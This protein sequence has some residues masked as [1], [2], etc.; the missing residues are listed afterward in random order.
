MKEEKVSW[1][2][3]TLG[4]QQGMLVFGES[5]YP[6][7][8]FPTSMG[9]Y[10]QNKDFKLIDSISW[11]IDNGFIK[12][13]CPDSID[14]LSW[15]NK[16]VHPAE[17]ASNH[18]AYD[19]MILNEVVPRAMAETGR[20]KVAM[21]GCSF[22]G[23][24]AVNFGFR[25]PEVTGY[26]FSMGAAFDIRGRVNGFYNDDVYFN[27]PIDFIPGLSNPAIYDIGIVLGTGTHDF[28][29]ES[30]LQLSG[31]LSAKG[32]EHWLDIVPDGVHDWP[33]WRYMFPRYLGQ[34]ANKGL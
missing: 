23:Y 2:S 29:L 27:N 31:I 24:H 9:R 26:I 19:Y 21:A 15:Y 12:V 28:C 20:N 16:G 4:I 10:Y 13:Y 1:Y 11:F 34:L 33:A 7:I 17:R 14:E 30:N 32:I 5:G 6:V 8:L 22:G 3:P 18:N 25:H